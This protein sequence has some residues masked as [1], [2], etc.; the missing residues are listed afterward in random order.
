MRADVVIENGRIVDP[1][2]GVD[3][4]GN[5][6]IKNR[7]I[8]AWQDGMEADET[9]D[10]AGCLVTPG[11]VDF[12]AHIFDRATDSGLNPDVAMLPHGVTTVVDAGCSGVATYRSFLDR[13]NTYKIKTKLLLHV[14]PVGQANHQFPEPL[15]P[16]TWNMDRFAAAFEIGGDKIIGLKV[17]ISKNIVKDDGAK[18]FYKALE[19]ARR[20][21]KPLVVHISNS[22]IPLD[23]VAEALAPG[24]VFCHVYQGIGY[25][26]L[27]EDGNVLPAVRKAQERGVVMDACHG[28]E[29]LSFATADAALAQN[30][31]PDVISS[32]LT[33]RTWNKRPVYG[34]PHVM[35]KF[36]H[37]GM[38]D[39]EII[40]RVTAIP[41]RLIGM[42]DQLGTLAE[43][44]WADIAVLKLAEGEAAF[45]DSAGEVRTGK[46]YFVP[47]ATVLD[48]VIVYRSHELIP[49]PPTSARA[50]S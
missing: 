8:A 41:A 1:A 29:N 24:D 17:R 19:V 26:I 2:N 48:G 45:V 37:L 47:M 35:S 13:L 27:G 4:V 42:A 28:L 12:H 9:I 15:H 43:G 7:G 23:E 11:L 21:D 40:R 31:L 5:I 49:A 32:D 6:A 33:N 36:L 39:T 20:F 38:D 46:K 22:A 16:D 34:L 14:C 50:T 25:T 10:A 3:R 30:F 18:I 44:T